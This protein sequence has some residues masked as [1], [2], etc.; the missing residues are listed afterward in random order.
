MHELTKWADLHKIDSQTEI[1]SDAIKQCYFRDVQEKLNE[2][3][4]FTW[5][6]EE[7]AVALHLAI[8]I[9]DQNTAVILERAGADV[10]MV[11]KVSNFGNAVLTVKDL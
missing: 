6:D 5:H 10:N 7:K 3:V 9:G 1:T 4:K 11:V 2:L 8:N